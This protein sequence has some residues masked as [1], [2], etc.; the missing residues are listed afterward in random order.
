MA[1]QRSS[2]FRESAPHP[3]DCG[4]RIL[5]LELLSLPQVLSVKEES[6]HPAPQGNGRRGPPRGTALGRGVE[7]RQETGL[8]TGQS[9]PSCPPREGLR[10]FFRRFRV[11]R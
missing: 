9:Q 10:A 6:P 8:E 1:L 7:R 4:H 5:I 11:A 3:C 2:S